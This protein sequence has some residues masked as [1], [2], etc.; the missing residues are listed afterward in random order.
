MQVLKRCAT[1]SKVRGLYVV[2]ECCQDGLSRKCIQANN[3]M[4]QV[5]RQ[6]IRICLKSKD[7]PPSSLC[8][9]L[10]DRGLREE[11]QLTGE[12]YRSPIYSLILETIRISL[13]SFLEVK[14]AL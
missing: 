8:Y 7:M 12:K 10:E 14:K 9:F 1:G 4:G 5:I 6:T 13:C 11:E 3:S 2:L